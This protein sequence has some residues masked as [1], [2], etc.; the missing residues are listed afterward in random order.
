MQRIFLA[1]C[2]VI[3]I[4]ACRTPQ[5]A[6][7]PVNPNYDRALAPGQR[8]LRLITDSAQWP[9]VKI[10]FN[11]RD[12]GLLE[13]LDRSIVWFDY[14]SARKAFPVSGIDFE[15]ARASAVA[16]RHLLITSTSS[17][18]FE[19]QM[20]R[21]FNAYTSVGYDN[22]GSVL[23]TGY[24]SPI[25]DASSTRDSQFQ[26]PL[27]RSPNDARMTQPRVT[28]E[29]PGQLAGL[30]LVYL[31][32]RLDQYLVHVQGSA[33]LNLTDGRTIHVGYA[34]TND[35]QYTSIGREL[36]K[37]GKL[38]K[39]QL[40]LPGL[41]AYF[42]RQPHDLDQYIQRNARFVFFRE[43]DG[44]TWP[45]GSM[46]FKVQTNRSLATDKTLFPRGGVV[47]VNTRTVAGR[48]SWF[49]LD[50]DTGGAIRASGRA[51]IYF[52]IGDPAEQMAGEQYAE[53]RLYYFYL[54]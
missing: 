13:A 19:Q 24:Y 34:G 35:H 10:A 26:Y 36:V 51:D 47:L 14:P 37:D 53:G 9:D 1:G 28:L 2:V 29:Q 45:S 25:F 39:Q 54:R 41:R 12:H 16:I 50:Q 42:K 21:Q 15:T 8:A 38:S 4:S 32:N 18:A 11:Q 44:A 7:S 20:R 52:G 49:M 27:Y 17:S 3:L 22:Q 23:Y 33:R 6:P 5:E 46:G 31:R 43:Y 40:S 30:E 48:I